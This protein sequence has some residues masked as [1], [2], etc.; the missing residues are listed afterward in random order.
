M[1]RLQAFKFELKV[2][3]RELRALYRIAGS[4][5]FVYNKAL[6]LQKEFYQNHA[7]KMTYAALCK[8][9]T[10]WRNDPEFPWL[11]AS[12]SQALQQSLKDLEYAY[13]NFFA[14]RADFPKFKR[15]HA[16]DAFRFPQGFNLDQMN[17]RIYLPKIGWIRYRNS[18][19]VEGNIA[20]ITVSRSRD[21]WY[22]SIQ[23]ER[24]VPEPIHLSSSA[25]GAD[26]GVAKLV[27]LSDGTVIESNNPKFKHYQKKIAAY[28]R[29]AS[30]QKKFSRNW[31]KTIRKIS[32]LHHK[33]S[34]I[35]ND[36]LHQ[37]SHILSKNHAMICLENLQIKNMSK[38]ASG[39]LE[40]PGKNVKAKSGLNK[41]ILNQ[42]WYELRR[43]LEYKQLWRGGSVVFVSPKNTSRECPDCRYIS[44]E[45]R[46]TQSLF[47]CKQCKY[48][49]NAD[50]VGAIN[51]LRAGHAQLACGEMVHLGHLMKQEPTEVVQTVLI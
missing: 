16:R 11:K 19:L 9:L 34:R 39:T 23:T 47:S 37:T 12:P 18:R 38:S 20:N 45:N 50:I 32:K 35:R 27:T 41:A 31:N 8:I 36:Y 15:R 28:Q 10:S 2:F 43:Q 4:C 25:I 14:K 51:I 22:V 48:E 1:K 33:I 40:N 29:K 21:K 30:K 17:S 24:D 7:K 3:G 42:G 46:V 5:R 44:S 6:A 49:N 26:V 13:Q